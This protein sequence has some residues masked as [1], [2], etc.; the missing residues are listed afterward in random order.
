[1]CDSKQ[2]GL[3]EESRGMSPPVGTLVIE[4][5]L[6]TDRGQF[7]RGVFSDWEIIQKCG[8]TNRKNDSW[9][10]APTCILSGT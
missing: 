1:M 2:Q 6:V 4:L 3:E 9:E 8:I 10:K 7:F 5:S